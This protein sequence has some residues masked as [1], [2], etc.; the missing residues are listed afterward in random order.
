MRIKSKDDEGI[1]KGKSSIARAHY[2][3]VTQLHITGIPI[4]VEIPQ[5]RNP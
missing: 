1:T 4:F 2:F 3:F 5:W